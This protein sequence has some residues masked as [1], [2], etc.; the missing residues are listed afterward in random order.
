MFF[1]HEGIN[2]IKVNE[3]IDKAFDKGG[4][5]QIA[6]KTSSVVAIDGKE[7]HELEHGIDVE[8]LEPNERC[9]E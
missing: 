5:D 1:E 3:I 4:D 6:S 8:E 9:V 7:M 2:E